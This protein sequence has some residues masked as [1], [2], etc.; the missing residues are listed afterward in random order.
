MALRVTVWNEYRHEREN[1]RIAEVYP[2]GMHVAI[3]DGIREGG[4]V[5]VR[6]AT[7]D[8]PEH[9]LTG[10]VLADD[11]RAGL[12]G[13]QGARRRRRRDRAASPGTGP[14]GDGI[15]R[16]PL[17]PLLQDLQ[18]ADGHELRPALA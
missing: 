11:G 16:P 14:D 5:E 7:L 15:D 17:G 1:A 2:D 13:P 3:A 10:D 4:D 8:E 9:G 18:G 12:V 6:T